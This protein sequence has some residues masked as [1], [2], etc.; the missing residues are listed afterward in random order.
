MASNKLRYHS[1]IYERRG[2]REIFGRPG[3]GH[4]HDPPLMGK[5]KLDW[6]GSLRTGGANWR[7]FLVSPRQTAIYVMYP[8]AH[9]I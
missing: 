2:R 3:F 1:K 8:T 4:V 5:K 6:R 9:D 7:I